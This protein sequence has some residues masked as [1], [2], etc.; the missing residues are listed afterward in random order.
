MTNQNVH[1]AP[2]ALKVSI[3]TP[4]QWDEIDKI[5]WAAYTGDKPALVLADMKYLAC[6]ADKKDVIRLVATRDDDILATQSV[7][8]LWNADEVTDYLGAKFPTRSTPVLVTGRA[9]AHRLYLRAGGFRALMHAAIATVIDIGEKV[10]GACALNVHAA[11]NPLIKSLVK[12]GWDTFDIERTKGVFQ[13]PQ[14]VTYLPDVKAAQHSLNL[15]NASNTVP[16]YRFEGN[17]LPDLLMTFKR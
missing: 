8:L 2:S 4:Q 10:G 1:S 9:A 6:N 14:A 3:A 7:Q 17:P 13:G 16:T 12:I 5:V 11:G 15:L